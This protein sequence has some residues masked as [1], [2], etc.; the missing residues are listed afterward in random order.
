MAPLTANTPQLLQEDIE[1]GAYS[2]SS[3]ETVAASRVLCEMQDAPD[4][5]STT[6]SNLVGERLSDKSTK[7]Q[8]PSK[9]LRR[10]NTT[11]YEDLK[12]VPLHGQRY[13]DYKNRKSLP[14]DERSA[15]ALA[16]RPFRSR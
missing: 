5:L 4:Q 8:T 9:L 11:V 1:F 7:W 2:Q 6:C 16:A 10:C 12:A 13:H 14:Q 3:G 15:S